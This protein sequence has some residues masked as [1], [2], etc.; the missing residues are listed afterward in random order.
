MP[1]S[2]CRARQGCGR[3]CGHPLVG[4]YAELGL[5]S[6]ERRS[7]GHL[8]GPEGRPRVPLLWERYHAGPIASGESGCSVPGLACW[9]GAEPH[10]MALGLKAAGVAALALTLWT[11]RWAILRRKD[12]SGVEGE[13]VRST[14]VADAL[15]QVC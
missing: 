15:Q 11:L 5:I 13:Q 6:L 1:C 10:N 3:V 2:A 12:D 9:L 7:S 8:A 14:L 4:L